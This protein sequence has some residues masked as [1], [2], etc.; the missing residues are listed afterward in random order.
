MSIA[1]AS[2]FAKI[3]SIVRA[4]LHIIII[5]IIFNSRAGGGGVLTPQNPPL[6]SKMAAA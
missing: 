3:I 4:N 1:I 6:P 2:F 5:F